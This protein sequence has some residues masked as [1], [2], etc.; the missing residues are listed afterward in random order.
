MVSTKWVFIVKILHRKIKRFKAR[1]VARGFTQKYGID[2]IEI[3]TPTVRINTLRIFFTI[4]AKFDLE[5]S[6]FDIKN[7]FI[8]SHFKEEIWFSTPNG[9]KIKKG[10]AFRALRSLYELK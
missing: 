5:C 1:L 7:A 3:F 4:V 6:H 10:Y 9:V 2:Y 8:E